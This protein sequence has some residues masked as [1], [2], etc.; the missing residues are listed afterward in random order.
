MTVLRNQGRWDTSNVIHDEAEGRVV[1]YD[2]TRGGSDPRMQYIDYGLSMLSRDVVARLPAGEVCD[3]GGLYRDLSLAGEL[4]GFEVTR[5]FYEI[6]SPEGL[7]DLERHLGE[8]G[9][10]HGN[11]HH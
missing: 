10:H 4:A 6:G 5:R 7:R 11:S 9:E 2:K 8:Q 3:L 1:L